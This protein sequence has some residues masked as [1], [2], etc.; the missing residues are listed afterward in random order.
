MCELANLGGF[1][2]RLT[3]SLDFS[4][5][6]RSKEFCDSLV[7]KV[8]AVIKEMQVQ[9]HL[10]VDEPRVDDLEDV[11][12]SDLHIASSYQLGQTISNHVKFVTKCAKIVVDEYVEFLESY[13]L[14]DIFEKHAMETFYGYMNGTK[15]KASE[16]EITGDFL[17]KT[18]RVLVA[19]TLV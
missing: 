8:D 9:V 16:L 5:K 3:L 11:I 17:Q 10:T 18:E 6:G 1:Q 12:K 7:K 2:I 19:N 15:M 14:S 4:T 13:G